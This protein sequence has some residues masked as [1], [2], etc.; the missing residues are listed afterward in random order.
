MVSN[1]MKHPN[2]LLRTAV[3]CVI[4]MS[5]GAILAGCDQAPGEAEVRQALTSAAGGFI[6]M[7]EKD[8]A[9]LKVLGCAKA[10][11]T[12]YICDWTSP[13]GAGSGRIVKTEKGWMLVEVGQ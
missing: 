1:D 3:R 5:A 7:V 9:Q 6:G 11:P 13:L 2:P 12:G 8:L 4:V 10:S